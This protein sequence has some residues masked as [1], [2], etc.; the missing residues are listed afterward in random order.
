MSGTER[1]S[2]AAFALAPRMR[3]WD[4][5]GPAPQLTYFF[6]SGVASGA[7]GRVERATRTAYCTT[8]GGAG[9]RLTRCCSSVS[10]A[11]VSTGDTV[12]WTSPVVAV[13]MRSSSSFEG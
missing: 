7:S 1:P 12:A 3:Y 4:A 6:T 2:I 5:R 10:W 13:T 9:S 8:V 11:A